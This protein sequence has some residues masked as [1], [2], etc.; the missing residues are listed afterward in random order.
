MQTAITA[1]LIY[2]SLEKVTNMTHIKH[3]YYLYLVTENV[4]LI[5]VH[6]KGGSILESKD[7]WNN[8]YASCSIISFLGME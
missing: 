2:T 6:F 8:Y 1:S 4:F 7:T 3:I 5:F